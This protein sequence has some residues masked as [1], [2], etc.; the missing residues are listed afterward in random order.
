M[1]IQLI[2]LFILLAV[3]FAVQCCSSAMEA[4]AYNRVTGKNVGWWDAMWIDLRAESEAR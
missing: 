2:L 1:I 3:A 4:R